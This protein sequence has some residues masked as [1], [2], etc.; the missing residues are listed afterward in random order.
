MPN[1]QFSKRRGSMTAACKISAVEERKIYLNGVVS[2]KG[3]RT[4]FVCL[5]VLAALVPLNLHAQT[6]GE[7]GIQGTVTDAAGAAI[8]N[9]TVTV[10]N[11][12][13]GVTLSRQTTGDGLY[14][15]SPILP[16]TYTVR[17][18]SQGFSDYVQRNLIANALVLTPLNMSMRVGAADTMVEVTDAPPQLERPMMGARMR[19]PL[20]PFLT[21]RPS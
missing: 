6:G 17:V 11:D 21:R 5:L 15:V 18:K 8:P 20:S 3:G 14:T 19:M 2:A 16:G 10:T 13:T 12:A 1:K 9:A 7:A 4:F